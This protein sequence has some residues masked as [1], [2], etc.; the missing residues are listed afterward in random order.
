MSSP[1]TAYQQSTPWWVDQ[2]PK[3][4]AEVRA[5]SIEK[6][7]MHVNS[8]SLNHDHLKRTDPGLLYALWQVGEEKLDALKEH[9]RS[10]RDKRDLELWR[11]MLRQKMERKLEEKADLARLER[12]HQEDHLCNK[13]DRYQSRSITKPDSKPHGGPL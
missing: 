2:D 9:K 3:K 6:L 10:V 7:F 11:E 1:C 5:L 12:E 13:P 4:V 8:L